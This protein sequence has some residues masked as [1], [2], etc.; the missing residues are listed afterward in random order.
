MGSRCLTTKGA[1]ITC[2]VLRGR[3]L[4]GLSLHRPGFRAHREVNFWFPRIWAGRILESGAEGSVVTRTFSLP[5]NFRYWEEARNNLEDE[6]FL[7][8]PLGVRTWASVN[9]VLWGFRW[10][11][12]V[13]RKLK[14]KFEKVHVPRS[15]FEIVKKFAP[16]STRGG[17]RYHDLFT[18]KG[19]KHSSILPDHSSD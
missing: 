2:L 19:M 9:T 3:I 13:T 15:I 6:T 16:Y 7:V 11:V 8:F 12:R 4:H 1:W 10:L 17:Y 14:I 5:H 18:D